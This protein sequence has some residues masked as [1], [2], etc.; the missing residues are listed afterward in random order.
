MKMAHSQSWLNQMFGGDGEDSDFDPSK[1]SPSIRPD[2]PT[3]LSP[4]DEPDADE[5][6]ELKAFLGEVVPEEDDSEDFRATDNAD[7]I[8]I[9]EEQVKDGEAEA[10]DDE[11]ANELVELD[12]ELYEDYRPVY[13]ESAGV[14]NQA[15]VA[16]EDASEKRHA[17]REGQEE[18]ADDDF[19]P[20]SECHH[21]RK[22]ARDAAME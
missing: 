12:H 3:M 14:D 9:D 13:Y 7:D 5:D 1:P 10:D 6:N 15:V 16:V 8:D 11:V 19:D 17:A 2:S 22:D 20:C 21:W 4:N 18:A